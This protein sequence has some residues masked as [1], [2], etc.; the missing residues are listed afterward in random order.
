[1]ISYDIA[2]RTDRPNLRLSQVDD[3]YF[4]TLLQDSPNAPARGAS[5]SHARLYAARGLTLS[6]LQ[7]KISNTSDPVAWLTRLY[8]YLDAQAKVIVLQV[9]DD[10][11]AYLIFETLNARGLDLSIADLVK[12]YVLGKAGDYALDGVLDAWTRSIGTLR[13]HGGEELF[14]DFLRQYWS[15]KYELVREKNLYRQI[16]ERL[17]SSGTVVS[18]SSDLA[19]NASLFA[20]ILSD[21]HE[22]WVGASNSTRD[23]IRALNLLSLVQYRPALLAAMAKWSQPEVERLVRLLI[24]WNTRILIEGSAGSGAIES[25]YSE[26]GQKIRSDQLRNVSD[27]IRETRDHIPSDSTFRT[28]MGATSISRVPFARYILRELENKFRGERGAELIPNPD[29]SRLTLEHVLPDKP[30]NNWPQFNSDEAR[31]YVNRLGN[32]ALL[33]QRLNSRLRSAPF[34]EKRAALAGSQLELTKKISENQQW[35]KGTIEARQNELAD[36][37]V[38]TWPLSI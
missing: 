34:P 38:Q 11:N 17:G 8:Q 16:K 7:G 29:A 10:S 4:Q 20:A 14:I 22:Y 35:D 19:E 28:A 12:N 5:D 26:L 21:D 31:A 15:S 6:W 32:L 33:A 24:N 36:L 27:V 23:G 18:F 25:M 1:M 2:S 13:S 37:A 30:L 9:T 3:L